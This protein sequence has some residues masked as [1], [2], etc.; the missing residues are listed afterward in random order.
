M[1][2]AKLNIWILW[3]FTV[4]FFA[5]QFV[6]RLSPGVLIDEIMIK[7][8]VNASTFG[9]IT[10]FYYMGYAGMQ[11]PVGILLDKFGIRYVVAISAF[12]CVLG[13]LPLIFSDHWIPALFGRFLIGIGSAAGALGAIHAVRINFPQKYMSKMIGFTITFSLLG[14]IYGKSIN[15]GLLELFGMQQSIIYISIPGIIVALGIL[16][17]AKDID[18]KITRAAEQYSVLSSLKLVAQ[19]GR[20]ILL[21]IAGALMVGPLE[22]FADIFGEP[23]FITVYNFAPVDA[24]YLTASAIYFGMCLG[25]PLLAAIADRFKC[26]YVINITCGMGMAGIFYLIL[27]KQVAGYAPMFALTFLIGIMSAYQ[28]LIISTVSSLVPPNVNGVAIATVNMINMIAGTAYNASIG[29]LLDYYWTGELINGKRLYS[30][31][32]YTD[33]LFILPITLMLGAILC[34]ILKPKPGIC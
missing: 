13:N 12:I 31:I 29:N 15:R 19:D 2:R 17:L 11:I 8:Q 14:A 32:A 25:A 3:S 1:D 21:S 10:A 23:Y 26:H 33:A 34:F 7:Y 5:Y 18:N 6:L 24:G 16:F 4:F 30:E 27:N 9:V 28:V 22:A 20:I